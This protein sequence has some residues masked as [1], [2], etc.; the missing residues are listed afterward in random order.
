MNRQSR[1]QQFR[2]A[3][4]QAMPADPE[5]ERMILGCVILNNDL[6]QTVKDWEAR[7]FWVRAHRL[8]FSAMQALINEGSAVDP[9]TLQERLRREGKL[10]EIGGP[11]FIAELFDGVPRFTNIDNYAERV[12]E[13]FSRREAAAIGNG[14]YFAALDEWIDGRDG[15]PQSL[16]TTIRRAE[17]AL[18]NLRSGS[19]Q[20]AIRSEWFATAL[21]RAWG[22]QQRPQTVATGFSQTDSLLLGGGFMPGDL[23]ILGARTSMGKSTMALQIGANVADRYEA[24]RPNDGPVVAIFALEMSNASLAR[25]AVGIRAELRWESMQRWEFTPEEFER[26]RPVIRRAAR[27]RIACHDIRRVTT[28]DIARECRAI[29][30]QA[31]RLDLVIVDHLGLVRADRTIE[32]R[33]EE[34]GYITSELKTMAGERGI[35]APFLVPTQINRGGL[36]KAKLDVDDLRDSGRIEEDADKIFIIQMPSEEM[37]DGYEVELT[38]AKQ[39]EGAVGSVNFWFDRRF[40]GFREQ[41]GSLVRGFKTGPRR[42]PQATE[43]TQAAQ[44][45]IAAASNTP[46]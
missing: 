2:E 23:I 14:L 18:F 38:L 36:A 20:S 31:G 24:E 29:R 37:P 10:E 45:A 17:D 6:W 22:D 4:E 41:P 9:L 11:A 27:W 25:K 30:R 13:K 19:A 8:V 42:R 21:D 16:E 7:V 33:V 5:M 28:A 39:R 34:L 43:A 40:G 44:A 1:Q 15:E 32:K 12:Y 26:Q 46:F 35:N 3:T